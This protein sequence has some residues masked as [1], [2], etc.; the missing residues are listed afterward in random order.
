[1]TS[2]TNQITANVAYIDD[3]KLHLDALADKFR[4]S[5]LE[6]Q[7]YS[8][9]SKALSF[10]KKNPNQF[11]IVIVDYV[12]GNEAFGDQVVREI[13]R[14]NPKIHTIILSSEVDKRLTEICQRAGA[15]GVY[16]KRSGTDVLISL[17]KIARLKIKDHPQSR[18]ELDKNSEYIKSILNLI[19]RSGALAKVARKVEIYSQS[20]D[21]VLILGKSGVGKEEIAKAIHKNSDRSH[22]PFIALNCGAF[23][24]DLIQSK[25]FGHRKGSFTGAMTDQKGSFENANG[26]TIFLDEIGE[27]PID[28]QVN[29][30]RAIQERT[31]TPVGSDRPVSFN[32]RI[33][34]ATNKDLKQMVIDGKFRDDLYYRLNVLPLSVP[35]LSER[36]EDIEPLVRH[37]ARGKKISDEALGHLNS[38]L[39]QGNVREL[40]GIIQKGHTEAGHGE[41]IEL[42]HLLDPNMEIGT[43]FEFEQA[44]KKESFPSYKELKK[45]FEAFEKKYLEKAL[46]LANGNMSEAARIACI[47]Y[48]SYLSKRQKFKLDFNP[49]I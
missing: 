45:E 29:L 10:I 5:T 13:K 11:K 48:T 9:P 1:M 42:A 47:P 36:T 21:T 34:A 19:G 18:M 20:K 12:L 15:D 35:P 23:A 25:L 49:N 31:V 14:I 17:S 8:E 40:Q 22:G 32:A 16:D 7:T 28:Q 44:T 43:P 46:T 30:L 39:W 38:R 2:F 3:D 33:I 27:M 41:M 6:V 24:K 26:G 37:F 4:Q